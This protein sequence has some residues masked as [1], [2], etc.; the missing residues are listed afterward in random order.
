MY[1]RAGPGES[2][3]SRRLR[4]A[5]GSGE[6]RV[7][8]SP[9]GP[10]SS[11]AAGLSVARR[12]LV[13]FAERSPATQADIDQ[14]MRALVTHDDWYV[15]VLFADRAWGQGVL[16]QRLPFPPGGPMTVLNG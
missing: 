1:S 13:D 8:S 15:P 3:R 12:A 6:D 7:V 5:T 10:S 14:V 16:D 4:V 11:T 9:G 2:V